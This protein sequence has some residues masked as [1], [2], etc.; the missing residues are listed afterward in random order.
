MLKKGLKQVGD[1][2]RN[3]RLH[4]YF[5]LM[6]NSTTYNVYIYS[7]IDSGIILI[8]VTTYH[9][10]TYS[11]IYSGSILIVLTTITFTPIVSLILGSS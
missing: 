6:C 5:T 10:Q 2:H 7:F 1:V 3:A 11:F 4:P 9:V 8:V